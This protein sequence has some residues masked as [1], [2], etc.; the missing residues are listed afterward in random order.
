VVETGEAG[1]ETGVVDTTTESGSDSRLAGVGDTI[2]VHGY[3][4]GSELAVTVKGVIDPADF[5][6][7]LGPRRGNKFVAV[8]LVIQNSGS[9]PTATR[10]G[11]ARS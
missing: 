3:E 9:S 4:E 6:R 10:P 5:E 11:T 8:D 2:T 1:G 7:Y